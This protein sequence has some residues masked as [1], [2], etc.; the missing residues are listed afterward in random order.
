MS[1][2]IKVCEYETD[3]QV[4]KGCGRTAEEITEWFTAT[5]DRKREIARTARARSRSAKGTG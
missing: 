4:C 1:I 2:C 5:Q 3:R